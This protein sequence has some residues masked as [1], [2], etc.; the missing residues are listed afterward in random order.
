MSPYKNG[1]PSE[2]IYIMMRTSK[3]WQILVLSLLA[4]TAALHAQTK[5]APPSRLEK[6][7]ET[8]DSPITVTPKSSTEKKIIEKREGGR[9]TEARVKSGNGSY[10]VKPNTPPGSALPGDALGSANRGPQWQVME[11]DLGAK[12]KKQTQEEAA[13]TAPPP[14]PAP[15]K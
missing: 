2:A 7:E 3:I 13:E 4:H 11:F 10:T 9:V 12:K 6:I 8:A 1:V 15:A 5:D 14:P